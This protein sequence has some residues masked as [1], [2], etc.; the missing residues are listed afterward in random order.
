MTSIDTIDLRDCID[1]PVHQVA[2]DVICYSAYIDW[3]RIDAG[4]C[5]AATCSG[6]SFKF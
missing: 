6:I 2:T 1:D 5:V 4:V 3:S